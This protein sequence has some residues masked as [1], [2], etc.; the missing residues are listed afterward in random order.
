[1]G[2]EVGPLRWWTSARSVLSAARLRKR[3]GS[4]SASSQL[5]CSRAAFDSLPPSAR[6]EHVRQ[7]ES[8]KAQETR[9]RRIAAVVAKVGGS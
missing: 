6:K 9:V 7:V 4:N 2:G 3:A 5:L 1:M 8:A